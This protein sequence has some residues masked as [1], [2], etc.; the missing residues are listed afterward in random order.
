MPLWAKGDRAD[1]KNHG[2]DIRSVYNFKEVL[3][4]GAFS[5]VVLAEEQPQGSGKFVAVK[6]MWGKKYG[7]LKKRQ[8]LKNQPRT[9]VEFFKSVDFQW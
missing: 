1:G 3:G 4:T 6:C 7:C 8:I 5:E 9:V 2:V